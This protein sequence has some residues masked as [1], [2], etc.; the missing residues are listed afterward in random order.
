MEKIKTGHLFYFYKYL[1]Q[2]EI[3]QFLLFIFLRNGCLRNIFHVIILKRWIFVDVTW[4]RFRTYH[5][6]QWMFYLLKYPWTF[7]VYLTIFTY[8]ETYKQCQII[9]IQLVKS[10]LRLPL[11]FLL[12]R[13]NVG[14]WWNL[15]IVTLYMYHVHNMK[16]IHNLDK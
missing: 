2:F 6:L 7:C 3:S 12:N 16:H 10:L 1:E 11:L 15:G 14:T 5:F 9:K 13:R 4:R 8:V